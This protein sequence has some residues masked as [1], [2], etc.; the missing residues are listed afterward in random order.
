MARLQTMGLVRTGRLI[1][2]LTRNSPPLPGQI[3]AW[4]E[5]VLLRAMER[6]C[7]PDL[8]DLPPP[9]RSGAL[10]AASVFIGGMPQSTQEE[11]QSMLAI[12]EFAPYAFGPRRRRLTQLGDDELDRFLVTL[13]TSPLLPA[14]AMFKAL[15]SV[16][17]M[18]YYSRPEVWGAIGYSLTG[19]PGVPPERV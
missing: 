6:M 9:S 16:C 17:M 4:L 7:A 5:A 19:N 10:S 12:V 1:A 14:R 15:K 13:E 18:G 11:L 3:P 2:R 8:D